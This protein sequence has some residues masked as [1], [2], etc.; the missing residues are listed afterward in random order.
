MCELKRQGGGGR[1][2]EA[3]TPLHVT[4]SR[5]RNE[6]E[7]RSARVWG[8]GGGGAGSTLLTTVRRTTRIVSKAMC[9]L[10]YLCS[11]QEVT[12]FCGRS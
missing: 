9:R 5:I 7:T 2:F 10:D 1:E 4:I 11:T 8:A 6:C 3:V 12:L